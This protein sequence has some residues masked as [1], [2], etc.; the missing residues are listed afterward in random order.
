MALKPLRETIEEAFEEMIGIDFSYD[1][2]RVRLAQQVHDAVVRSNIEFI[3]AVLGG[4][5]YHSPDGQAFIQTG[6]VDENEISDEYWE[7]HQNEGGDFHE[8]DDEADDETDEEVE[9][10]EIEE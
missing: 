9:E 3:A 6:F 5:I 8:D 7:E 10:D 1:D 2:D 4:S